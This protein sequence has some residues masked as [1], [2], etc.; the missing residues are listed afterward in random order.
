MSIL[1]RTL[2]SGASPADDAAADP[3]V[4]AE[5]APTGRLRVAVVVGPTPSAIYAVRDRA[6][7]S[8]R[9]V[10]VTLA[11][12]LAERAGVPLWFVPLRSTG[13]IQASAAGGVW[14][15]SFLPVDDERRALV[16]FGSAYHVLRS[17][18]LVPAGS[19]IRVLADA[20]APG[21]RITGVRDTATLRA[22][23]RA[24]PRATHLAVESPEDL[25]AMMHGGNADAIAMGRESL[26]GI[27][28]EI[29][30]SRI[31]DGAFL[32]TSTAVAVPQGRPRAR[33]FAAAVVEEAKASGLVREA[34]D[35]LGLTTAVVAPAGTWP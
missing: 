19:R 3:R 17:T 32:T 35:R 18:Y 20:D 31:L 6:G 27:A 1:D 11:Q 10:T 21:T 33:A 5:L 28:G 13:E 29:E 15:V 23:M 24:S 12:M 34:F 7:D 9:G 14:D 16:D 4:L 30:G 2:A 8:L 26:G 22:S 25:V